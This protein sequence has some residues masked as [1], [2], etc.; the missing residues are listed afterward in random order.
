MEDQ[1]TH[2]TEG[3][4]QDSEEA[5]RDSEGLEEEIEVHGEIQGVQEE[6]RGVQEDHQ[7]SEGQE[8]QEDINQI[9]TSSPVRWGLKSS[10]PVT[11][12]LSVPRDL[13]LCFQSAP[14]LP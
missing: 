14:Y 9:P 5:L 11:S 13:F 7:D 3:V 1:E 12:T 8:I 6:I 10:N 4:R 2:Q